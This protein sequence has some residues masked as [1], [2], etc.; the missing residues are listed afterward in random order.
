M[1][2]GEN[3][4][5]KKLFINNLCE[6]P[7]FGNQPS[8]ELETYMGFTHDEVMMSR[9]SPIRLNVFMTKN[10]RYNLNNDTN[11]EEIMRFIV[12]RFENKLAEES[13]TTR[14]KTDKLIHLV[15]YLVEPRGKKLRESDISLL[16]SMV[17]YAN[18]MVVLTKGDL[19][20]E[21]EKK[22]QKLLICQSLKENG[23]KTYDFLTELTQTFNEDPE[24]IEYLNYL[25][26]KQPFTV[27][28][29]RIDR[30]GP[31]Q[32]DQGINPMF[33]N[34]HSDFRILR[35]IIFEMN[36]TEF[37]ESTNNYIYEMFRTEKLTN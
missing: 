22:V 28:N 3:G 12:S 10:F 13:K 16:R 9:D 5:G 1:V 20:T 23:L 8:E 35:D 36:L 15:V 6:Q 29:A 37:K 25:Q 21:G 4:A 31:H 33:I 30:E 24:T 17:K 34:Q 26:N 2:I 19:M 14:M 27:I 32:G 11:D 18:V 7:V